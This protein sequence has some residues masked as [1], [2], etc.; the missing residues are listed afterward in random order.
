MPEYGQHWGR[1]FESRNILPIYLNLAELSDG[2]ADNCLKD[3][4]I[5]QYCGISTAGENDHIRRDKLS[6]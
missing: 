4:I 3:K 5:S 2:C 1:C 6:I